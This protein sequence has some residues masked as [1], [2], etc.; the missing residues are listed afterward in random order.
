[1]NQLDLVIQLCRMMSASKVEDA[2]L[3]GEIPLLQ[4]ENLAV[5]NA[6]EDKGNYMF[7]ADFDAQSALGKS[8]QVRNVAVPRLSTEFF[9]T[10]WED[11]L[12]H[13]NFR[14]AKPAHF[15]VMDGDYSSL[16][17]PSNQSAQRYTE[18]IELIAF[19]EK[20]A[21]VA[22]RHASA[23]NFVFLNKEKL[24]VQVTYK[25]E[26]LRNL[27]SLEMLSKEFLAEDPHEEQRK[28][29]FKAVLF[30]LLK[31][32]PVD[33]RFRH[34]LK[35]FNELTKRARENYQLYVAGFSFEK[36]KAEVESNRMEYTLKLNKVFSE[37]QNQLLA[38]PAALLLI[39]SQLENLSKFTLKN[40]SVLIGVVVFSFFM[41]MLLKNQRHSLD[42]IRMEIEE[43]KHKL[44]FEHA[45]LSEKLMPA[46]IELDRRYHH[47]KR[48]LR[49]V[50]GSIASV[51]LFSFWLFGRYSSLW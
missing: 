9:A 15:F 40:L 32:V 43:L 11:L 23:L 30:E 29:L 26:D 10:T 13:H 36:V 17:T 44:E 31:N 24:E 38:I 27:P 21:D 8:Y 25:A 46:Y 4:Q 6:L 48:S 42:A 1:M 34:L 49:I 47:Q 2:V 5:L 51:A 22:Q 39:S 3:S 18:I 12:S 45:A 37:I 28:S 7:N 33:Q 35:V 50:D 16:E 41:N 19:L 20:I 14:Y